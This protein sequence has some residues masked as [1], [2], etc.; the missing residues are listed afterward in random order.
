MA[1]V[2]I[3]WIFLWF[4]RSGTFRARRVRSRPRRNVVQ[5]TRRRGRGSEMWRVGLAQMEVA[6][7]SHGGTLLYGESMRILLIIIIK[8]D[9]LGVSPF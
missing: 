9:D 8:M 3:S 6:L 2:V 1:I 4:S 7:L 5:R